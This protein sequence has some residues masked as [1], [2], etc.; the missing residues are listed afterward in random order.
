[1]SSDAYEI[2]G[3]LRRHHDLAKQSV[4]LNAACNLPSNLVREIASSDALRIITAQVR[5]R[6][7]YG[8]T[9]YLD[10]A[11]QN[12]T[13][14]ARRLFR[15]DFASINPMSGN[16]AIL[17]ALLG[18]L[19][20][21]HVLVNTPSEYGGYP[22]PDR[23][24]SHAHYP[25]H[26]KYF[27]FNPDEWNINLEDAIQSVIRLKPHILMLGSADMLFPHPARE[28]SNVAQEVG[29][30]TVFDG[31]HVLGLIA[32]GEFQ[33][34]LNEGCSVLT[35][36]TNKSFPGPHRGIILVKGDREVFDKVEAP[37]RPPPLLQ[38]TCDLGTTI[39]VGIACAE[40]LE[41]GQDYVHQ[42][43]RNARVLGEALHQHGVQGLVCPHRG[44]TNSHML[45]Q[46]VGTSLASDE[47][48]EVKEKLEEA[49]IFVDAVVRYG[50]GEVTRRGMKEGE[51]KHLA[52]LIAKVL[53]EHIDPKKVRVEVSELSARFQNVE[54]SFEQMK[55]AFAYF[56]LAQSLR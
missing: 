9:K 48:F 28:L 45:I 44:F 52:E 56:D 14:L 36:G 11:I 19:E 27:P 26:V 5:G 6:S 20:P 25:F 24:R 40:M 10:K 38:S 53:V 49:N 15:A 17:S 54:Y 22:L 32:G 43:V 30:I 18:L 13:E 23:L 47:G 35:G 33:D 8:G 29:A 46:R 2:R 1:M 37:S 21:D 12:S 7:V 34:P 42:V 39:A 31:A 50:V 4:N 41:F 16:I 55:D 51:M 3:L